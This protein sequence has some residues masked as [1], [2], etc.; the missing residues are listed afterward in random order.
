ML[1]YRP[2]LLMAPLGACLHLGACL[3]VALL[4]AACQSAMPIEEAPKASPADTVH[5]QAFDPQSLIGE[6]SGRVTAMDKA[7]VNGTLTLTIRR[8]NGNAVF[9]SFERV[10]EGKPAL[11]HRFRGTLEGNVLRVGGIQFTVF[12]TRMIGHNGAT[13]VHGGFD[14]D[15]MKKPTPQGN[16]VS[17]GK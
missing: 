10:M 9:G 16:P 3:A 2:S 15:L 13:G 12:K 1:G 7:S 8:V 5:A 14:F 4:G 11:T 17:Q 6:W